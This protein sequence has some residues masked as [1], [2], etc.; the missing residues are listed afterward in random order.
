MQKPVEA[1]T[2]D[3]LENKKVLDA[4]GLKFTG[5]VYL[6]TDKL[7]VSEDAVR[8]HFAK[9]NMVLQSRVQKQNLVL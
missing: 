3:D 8:K 1:S 5:N 4:S 6:Y 7:L 2:K 9:N